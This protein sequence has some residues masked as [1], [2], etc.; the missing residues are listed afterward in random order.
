MSENHFDVAPLPGYPVEYGLLLSSLQS[1]TH[2]GRDELGEVDPD[3]ICWQPCPNGHSIGGVLLHIAEVEAYWIEEFSLGRIISPEEAK[4]CMSAQIDQHAGTWPTPHHEPLSF[5]YE[6]LDRIRARTLE[7]L[8][9]FEPP[10]TIKQSRWGTMTL[11]WVLA[12]VAE[13]EAYHMGQAVLLK[14]MSTHLRRNDG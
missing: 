2:E 6:L 7:S 1:V 8:R 5:Y 11:R 10:D 9:Q 3:V 4:M 12:H 13:H 14:H